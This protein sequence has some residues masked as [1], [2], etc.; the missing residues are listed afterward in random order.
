[1]ADVVGTTVIYAVCSQNDYTL[2]TPTTIT[3]ALPLIFNHIRNNRPGHIVNLYEYTN[4]VQLAVVKD[5]GVS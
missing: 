3:T 1:M 2:T 5:S 4:T